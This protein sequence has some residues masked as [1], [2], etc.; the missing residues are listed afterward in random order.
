MRGESHRADFHYFNVMLYDVTMPESS[1]ESHSTDKISEFYRS[2]TF[3]QRLL[4]ARVNIMKLLSEG[5]QPELSLHRQK[6]TVLVLGRRS[7]GGG[8][9]GKQAHLGSADRVT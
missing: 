7:A 8:Q 4:R 3:Q 6:V 1:S 9:S 5:A 2:Q